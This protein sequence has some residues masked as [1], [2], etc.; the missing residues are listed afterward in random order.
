MYLLLCLW[1]PEKTLWPLGKLWATIENPLISFVFKKKR[2][3]HSYFKL[4]KNF[5]FAAR[6]LVVGIL[7]K[8]KIDH[9]SNIVPTLLGFSS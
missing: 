2:G 9:K 5:M 4:T 7:D 3:L 6:A 1:P 8:V